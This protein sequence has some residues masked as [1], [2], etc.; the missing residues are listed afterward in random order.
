MFSAAF[1][2]RPD[3]VAHAEDAVGDAARMEFLQRVHL[4]ADTDQLD[5]LAGDGA[6]R[7]RRTAAAVAIHAG[8]HQAGDA[9]PLVEGAGEIDRVLA[10]QRIRDQQDLMRRRDGLDLRHL[11]HQRLVDMGAAGGVEDHHIVAAELCR[12]HRALGDIDRRLAGDDRQRGDFGL[13]AE[14]A[15]L[16]LRGRTARV[17]RGHQDLLALALGQPLGDLGGGGGLAR[18]LQADHHDDDR[19]RRIEIDGHAFGAQHLDQLVMDDL[20]DHLAGLDRLQHSG[21]DG[22]GAHLVDERADHVERH[23]GL[24]QRAAHL[25]QRRRDIRLGQRARGRSGR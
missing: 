18:A 16:L 4:F 22:L 2:T 24:E 14:L 13:L 11:G 25:A 19:R 1:S 7:K 23:V 9:D 20:D 5:R 10:G 17:E 6:H 12:L 8:Q 15:Q 21:A 3:D